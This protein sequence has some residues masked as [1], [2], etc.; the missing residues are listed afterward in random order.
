MGLYDLRCALSGLS[1]SSAMGRRSFRT[2]A[3]LLGES[4]G[5]R[6]PLVPP[7]GG[8]YDGY[9]RVELWGDGVE[10]AA[11][12]A[13][14]GE[15]LGLLWEA[16][17]L[18]SEASGK[19]ARLVA[20][21]GFGGGPGP[22]L[23]HVADSVQGGYRV[24]IGGTRVVPC[25]YR[26]DV[27]EEIAGDASVRGAGPAR[28]PLLDAFAPLPPEVS[29]G[30]A[31]LGRVLRWAER[32]GGLAPVGIDDG[33]QHEHA[34]FD[35]FAREA[36]RR[37]AVLRRMLERWQ[38][39][40]VAAQEAWQ[41]F[42]AP[43]GRPPT[44]RFEAAM[45]EPVLAASGVDGDERA[46]LVAAV[47][48]AGDPERVGRLLAA[49]PSSNPAVL[50][51]FDGVVERRGGRL[52]LRS[53]THPDVSVTYVPGER[54]VRVGDG[55]RVDAGA[56][57]ADGEIDL[58]ELLRIF[59]AEFVAGRMSEELGGLLGLARERAATLVAPMLQYVRVVDTGELVSAERWVEWS[60]AGSLDDLRAEAA[61]V[62]YPTARSHVD[63]TLAD[64]AAA[65]ARRAALMGR[66]EDP[67]RYHLPRDLE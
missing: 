14:V 27:A 9:G 13:W 2:A 51:E 47:A 32:H 10:E 48:A 30:L 35:R 20:D 1:L 67:D 17:V 15:V 52:L 59:G 64:I 40:D 3:L 42:N 62:G 33:S 31:R 19:L 60:E 61:L 6:V 49:T 55:E 25:F 22:F 18:R 29:E 56:V 54:A 45:L 41:E 37:D 8:H 21:G 50:A 23:A 63:P 66:L 58:H 39:A 65:Q 43:R 38:R 5:R 26:E 24:Y 28:M 36:Y 16:G 12:A 44:L 53:A 11:H 34:D 57:L 7:V 4:E 46:A